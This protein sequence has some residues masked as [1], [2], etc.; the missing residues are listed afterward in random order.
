M[1]WPAADPSIGRSPEAVAYPEAPE[2]ACS[3]PCRRSASCRPRPVLQSAKAVLGKAPPPV[4]DNARL[5][6]HFLGDRTGAATLSRQQHYSRPLHV[7]LR[8]RRCPAA[9]LKHLPYLRLEPNLSC[10]GNH[11]ILES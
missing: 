10:F 1:P 7:A 4:A 3:W 2:C 6:P 9:R 8:R 5:N 11:S